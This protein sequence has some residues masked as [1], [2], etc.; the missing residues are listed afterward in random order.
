MASNVAYPRICHL[1][2]RPD[3]F[4]YGFKLHSNHRLN[5]PSHQIYGIEPGSP[6]ELAGLCNGDRVCFV[7]NVR[8]SGLNH[9]TIVDIINAGVEYGGRLHKSE[10]VLVVTDLATESVLNR[11]HI[12]LDVFMASGSNTTP[13]ARKKSSTQNHQTHG[14]KE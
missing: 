5:P 9:W 11:L 12:D 4:G 8:V 7:N 10:V 1:K 6:A 2:K 14:E 13:T 3:Y